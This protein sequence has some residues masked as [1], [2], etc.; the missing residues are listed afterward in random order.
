M[1]EDEIEQELHSF[2]EEWAST[3]SD[4]KK[5]IGSKDLSQIDGSSL[6]VQMVM[7][8]T[9]VNK[10]GMSHL[11]TA[12]KGILERE[13]L[14]RQITLSTA[15][16]VVDQVITAERESYQTSGK[17][18]L[19]HVIKQ[20]TANIRHS[21]TMSGTFVLPANIA[22]GVDHDETDL[23]VGPIKIVSRSVLDKLYPATPA[24]LDNAD[25]SEI[26]G[27]F[28]REV[29]TDYTQNYDH[30]ILVPINNHE[31]ELGKRSAEL[32]AEFVLNLLRL[33]VGFRGGRRILLAGDA[34]PKTWTAELVVSDI[35]EREYSASRGSYGAPFEKGWQKFFTS[36]L[37]SVIY[38]T[39][40]LVPQLIR[41][42]DLSDPVIERLVYSNDLISNSFKDTYA[43]MRLVSITS[44]L[45][46]LTM[47]SS[48]DNLKADELAK[49]CSIAGAM[50]DLQR[51]SD[52]Y[53]QVYNAYKVRNEIVHGDSPSETD[54]YKA[55]TPL[56]DSLYYV[57]LK[58][59]EFLGWLQA[60]YSP[61]SARPLR[62]KF[63]EQFESYF[64][65]P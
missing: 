58:L 45:E 65:S 47:L 8:N 2:L 32:G 27:S 26:R 39:T 17:F 60:N 48:A 21:P 62:R 29:W 20:S 37:N 11:V 16:K 34:P 64:A 44:A 4:I 6:S 31:R 33:L 59:I 52:I 46:A 3:Q 9:L 63:T 25:K 12:A 13:H 28:S 40:S 23:T 53:D 57:V 24:E 50:G 1:T 55:M 5:S 42:C 38:I 43:P 30:F 10:I 51:K 22:M 41:G 18:N 49:R 56:E 7:G 54:I 19:K 35:N 61:Q 15:V 36:H 14:Q